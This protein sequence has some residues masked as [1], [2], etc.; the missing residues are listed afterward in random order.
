MIDD[1]PSVQDI[2][3]PD[4]ETQ[5]PSGQPASDGEE[6]IE[7]FKTDPFD[8]ALT[9]LGMPKLASGWEVGRIL[10]SINPR[11]PVAMITGWGGG[12]G[13]E[14]MRESGI[15]SH[16]LEAFSILNGSPRLLPR[17]WKRGRVENPPEK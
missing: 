14:K 5:R 2:F 9:D 8:L 7:R 11:V 12:T 13:L 1:D 4:A 3:W 16:H 10:K 6:G 15:D 17:R